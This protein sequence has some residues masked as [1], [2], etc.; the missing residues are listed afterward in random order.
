MKTPMIAVALLVTGCVTAPVVKDDGPS[1][2]IARYGDKVIRQ[3][4]V[5]AR[6]GDELAE[7]N[8]QIFKLRS[9]AAERIAIEAIVAQKSLAAGQSEDKWLAANVETGIA[10]P[11]EASM[12]ALFE[13]AKSR[14]PPDVEFEDVKPQLAQVLQREL[15][16]KKAKEV[17]AKL[18]KEAGYQLDLQAPPKPRKT[19]D[20]TGPTRGGKDAKVV[21]VE[22]ADFQ[23]PFCVRAHDTVMAVLKAYGDK[24]RIVFRHYPLANHAKAPK[25]AEAAACA[26]EQGK[27]WQM[28]DALFESQELEEDALRAQAKRL[29]LDDKKF[30]ECLGSGR[31]ASVVKRDMASGQKV[32]VSGT[33]AFFINGISLSGARS[34]DEFREII[35]AEL[36]RLG[37]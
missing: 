31:T 12:R 36:A 33:P 14:L 26:D 10:E 28:H 7:L 34:E 8:D 4:E 13:R 2:I 29:G 5:D 35:D 27:F 21:I 23:C 24:V 18:K 15:R 16:A 25:A 19:V 17:F 32:G 11:D 1:P 20:A 6:I 3:T 30:G 9:E 37:Q 22:Y